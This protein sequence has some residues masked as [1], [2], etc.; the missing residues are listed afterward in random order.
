MASLLDIMRGKNKETEKA[1][2]DPTKDVEAKDAPKDPA[3]E[4]NMSDLDRAVRNAQKEQEARDAR[5][6]EYLK[7][8]DAGK[9]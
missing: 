8:K 9:L 4:E 3:D 6:N 7:G 2:D 1:I 5:E